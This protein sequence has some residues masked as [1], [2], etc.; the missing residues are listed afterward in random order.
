MIQR[1]TV[2]HD[3]NIIHLSVDDTGL[4]SYYRVLVDGQYFKYLSVDSGIYNIEDMTWPQVLI[5]LL[6][7]LPPGEWNLGHIATTDENPAPHFDWTVQK[8]FSS[9][10]NAWHP[11]SVNYLSLTMGEMLF[12]TSMRL[13][14]HH[15]RTQSL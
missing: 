5:P 3:S 11:V 12:Q 7:P 4:E 13:L 10:T 14:R 2:M 8:S 15:F 6:P 9:I 1:R